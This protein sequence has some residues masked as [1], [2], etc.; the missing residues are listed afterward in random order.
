MVWFSE[1]ILSNEDLYEHYLMRL[2][3][4][5]FDAKTKKVSQE[6]GDSRII[7]EKCV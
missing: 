2:L 4:D 6:N 1:D 3:E 7:R 5:D